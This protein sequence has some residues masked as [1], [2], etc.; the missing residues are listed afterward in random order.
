MYAE[1]LNETTKT[2]EAHNYLKQVRAR[3]GLTGPDGLNKEAFTL[4]LEKE[5][6][7]EFLLEGHRWFDLVRTGRLQ[8]VMNKY[9]TDMGLKFSVADHE[10]IMPIPQRERDIN[11][12]LEQNPNY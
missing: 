9:F 11:P 6:R 12:Q 3:A 1:V 5:R 2:G 7:V 4:A 10:L 8:T